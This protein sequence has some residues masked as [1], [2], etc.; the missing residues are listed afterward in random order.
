[1]LR[2]LPET[3]LTSVMST[4]TATATTTMRAIRSA[5]P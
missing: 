2:L 4:T 3:A 1:M 5:C